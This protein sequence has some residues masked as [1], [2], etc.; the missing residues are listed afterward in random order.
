MSGD[1]AC[2]S[3][4]SP[5][6]QSIADLGYANVQHTRGADRRVLPPQPVNQSF[7]GDRFARVDEKNGEKLPM[8]RSTHLDRNSGTEDLQRPE[9]PIFHVRLQLTGLW[10]F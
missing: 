6:P 10:T 3:V 5:G 7:G 8:P 9:D 2:L 1:D 4:R